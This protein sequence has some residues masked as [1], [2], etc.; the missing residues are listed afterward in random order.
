MGADICQ[1]LSW[2]APPNQ[3]QQLAV[4]RSDSRQGAGGITPQQA[5]DIVGYAARD[6]CPNG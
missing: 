2:G 5:D 4:Q 1:Q 6:L 3:L